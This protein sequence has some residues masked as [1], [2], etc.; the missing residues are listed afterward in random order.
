MLESTI[1]FTPLMGLFFINS[2]EGIVFFFAN[3]IS[4]KFYFS[5]TSTYT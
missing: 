4:R 2:D 5:H 3:K 1:L